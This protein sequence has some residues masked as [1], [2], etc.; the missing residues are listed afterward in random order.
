MQVPSEASGLGGRQ[1]DPRLGRHHVGGRVGIAQ[2][3]EA[4]QRQDD[5]AAVLEGR[6][7]ADE[8]GIAALGH[9]GRPGAMTEAQHRGHLG[10][11][12]G[13]HQRLGRA[14][15]KLAR[16]HEMAGELL[17]VGDDVAGANDRG[18]L[19]EERRRESGHAWQ[20]S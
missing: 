19:I 11:A 10:R 17:R 4:G 16:L 15:I 7:A 9:H 14:A 18:E 13:P 5:L 20:G 6:L 2:A 3:V 1:R 12:A 8:T